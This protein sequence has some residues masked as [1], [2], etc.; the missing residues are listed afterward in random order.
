M[1]RL[2]GLQTV[3]LRRN[4]RLW[5]GASGRSLLLCFQ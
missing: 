2:T 1:R 5:L 3:H 4:I